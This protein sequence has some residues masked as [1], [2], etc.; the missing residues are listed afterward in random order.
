MRACATPTDRAITLCPRHGRNRRDG[1]VGR[2]QA[3]PTPRKQARQ[4]VA[5]HGCA[6]ART[7]PAGRSA[8]S[9]WAAAMLD[10]ATAELTSAL[11]VRRAKRSDRA[12]PAADVG[13][14]GGGA[15]ARRAGA[16]IR[17]LQGRPR[18]CDGGRRALPARALRRDRR[19]GRA[20]RRS[21]GGRCRVACGRCRGSSEPVADLAVAA[22]A[23]GR[24]LVVL[25]DGATGFAEVVPRGGR[26]A[27][28]TPS[29]ASG[30]R[31]GPG[32]TWRTA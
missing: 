10:E 20:S 1:G 32:S 2:R 5:D 27:A 17:D 25:A 31:P 14:R 6:R 3:G 12:D 18:A 13:T 11:G 29:A 24:G 21:T 15:P 7:W 19:P 22:L 26:S 23:H 8:M 30:R 16:R 4:A 28:G 9:R